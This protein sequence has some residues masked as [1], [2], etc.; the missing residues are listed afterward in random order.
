MK[1]VR[2]ARPRANFIR[3]L[4]VKDLDQLGIDHKGED[5]VWDKDN[6]FEIVMSNKMSDSLVE[7]L[8]NEFILFDSDAEDE[9]VEVLD[10]MTSLASQQSELPEEEPESSESDPDDGASSSTRTSSRKR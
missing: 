1:R 10:P 2:Y 5:L 9:P 7:K 4:R 8:P 3:T 6:G